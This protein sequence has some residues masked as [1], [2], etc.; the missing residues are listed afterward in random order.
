[1]GE[2]ISSKGFVVS[3]SRADIADFMIKQVSDSEYA[4]KKARVM[5]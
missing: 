4:H 2:H 1:V 3:I 5:Y